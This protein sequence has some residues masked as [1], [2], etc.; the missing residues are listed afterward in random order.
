M[1]DSKLTERKVAPNLYRT[2]EN[3]K[4]TD[5]YRFKKDIGGVPISKR[6][7]SPT[8]TE[9]KA[10]A[11][12]LRVKRVG[13]FGDRSMTVKALAASY[14]ERET[15]P[16]AS[17]ALSTALDRKAQ[18][19]KYVLPSFGPKT[20]VADVTVIH[21]R[22]LLDKLKLHKQENG[23]PLAGA[24]IIKIVQAASAMFKHG[25]VNLGVISRNPRRDLE[26]GELPSGKRI[27]EPRYLSEDDLDLVFGALSDTSRPVGKTCFWAATR[28][29]ET[30]NLKWKH[31]DFEQDLIRVPGT[32]SDASKG[33]IPMHSK[34]KAVLLAH[35]E[36]QGALGFDRIVADA[37]VF[38]TASGKQKDRHNA[39]RAIASA[40]KRVGLQPEG[41]EPLGN[42]DLR[43]S[44]AAVLYGEGMNDEEVA[45]F[46]RH[47]NSH[48]AKIMYAGMNKQQ[49]DEFAEKFKAIGN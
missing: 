48:T 32:K 23:E 1:T 4:P 33:T 26:P 14:I 45:H 7:T 12:T 9:A 6:F 41:A 40:A 3:D 16:L 13:D 11:N 42:H 31:L 49:M 35:R 28:I 20:K 2:F 10:F 46:M 34:L 27:T 39:L 15:G 44:L 17:V 21:V 25:V 24:T 22:R 30:L 5:R 37:F 29:S 47:G 18:L 8:L 36:I 38:Q 43:H 19:D